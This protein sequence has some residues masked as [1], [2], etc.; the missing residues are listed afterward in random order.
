MITCLLIILSAAK[1]PVAL[2]LK[3]EDVVPDHIDAAIPSG[4]KLF[5]QNEIINADT[6]FFVAC[7]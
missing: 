7:R 1:K 5:D 6:L 4:T 2:C 3:I